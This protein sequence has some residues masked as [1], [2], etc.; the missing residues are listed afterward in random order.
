LLDTGS[1]VLD[2]LLRLVD[3]SPVTHQ[4]VEFMNRGVVDVDIRSSLILEFANGVRADFTLIG[5]ATEETEHIELYG[6]NGTA[7][8]QLREDKPGDLYLREAGKSSVDIAA[9][10]HRIPLPDAAFVAAL[11]AGGD[12]TKETSEHPHSAA[13]A[14][15]VIELV[16]SFYENAVWRTLA[17]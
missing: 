5:D 8:W 6:L 7:G 17:V 3:G 1:S 13:S 12:F 4:V 14:L 15:P 9:S 11:R 10:G 16:Q 2:L